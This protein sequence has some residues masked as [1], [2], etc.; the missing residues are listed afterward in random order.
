MMALKGYYRSS[1]ETI[2]KNKKIISI[3]T[4]VYA[5]SLLAGMVYYNVTY[6]GFSSIEEK[7]GFYQ[8][9]KEI[10]F[11]ENF[12][13]NFSKI[14]IHNFIA[15]LLRIGGGIVFGI[16]PIFLIVNDAISNSYNIVASTL[17]DGIRKALFLFIPHSVFEIPAFILSSSFGLI[18][19]LSLFKKGRKI[20]NLKNACKES[21][22]IFLLW[23]APLLLVAG[24]IESAI[25][26]A[27]WF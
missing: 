27:Y 21:L 19:F 23:I 8:A 5:V 6:D 12:F 1:M 2:K 17:D 14:F 11:D 15:S 10:N 16:I 18:I 20:H 4:M 26:V 25:I 7:E 22:I 3:I 9:M 13:V 24:I